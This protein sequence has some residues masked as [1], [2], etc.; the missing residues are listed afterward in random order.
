LP[1]TVSGTTVSTTAIVAFSQ[2]Q[3]QASGSNISNSSGQITINDTG[4]Y[5]VSFG[6]NLYDTTGNI[7]F[8]LE[9][10]STK[11]ITASGNPNFSAS[12]ANTVISFST[13]IQLTSSGTVLSVKNTGSNNAKVNDSTL[14]TTGTAAYIT[15]VKLQ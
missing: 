11:T 14:D 2:T 8:G 10:G 15:I 6:A 3:A 12:G 7:Q 1:G 9:V 4:F 5:L 13:V